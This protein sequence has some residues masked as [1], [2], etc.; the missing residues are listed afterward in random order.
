[1]RK[2]PT[3]PAYVGG[4]DAQPWRTAVRLEANL[5]RVVAGNADR[6]RDRVM[7]AIAVEIA[8]MYGLLIVLLLR[9]F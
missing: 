8:V 4:S 3:R 1:M 7:Y 9:E 5:C 2:S 6:K